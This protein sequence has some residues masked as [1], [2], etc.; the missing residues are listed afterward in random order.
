VKLTLELSSPLLKRFPRLF[1]EAVRVLT[2]EI[3]RENEVALRSDPRVPR[4]Y[5]SGVYYKMVLREGLTFVDLFE[6]LRKGYGH[7]QHLVG[8][9]VAELRVRDGERGAQPAV[10]WR[11]NARTKRIVFHVVVRRADG[12]VEDPSKLLGMGAS[13]WEIGR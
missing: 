10:K 6:V 9:R 12:S 7:C 1:G 13:P 8:W 11:H 2:D 4:L 3:A 5:E